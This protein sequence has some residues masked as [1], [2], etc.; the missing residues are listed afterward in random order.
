MTSQMSVTNRCGSEFVRLVKVAGA[1][2]PGSL[3]SPF[4]LNP[5][6]MPCGTAGGD[7][8]T[9]SIGAVLSRGRSAKGELRPLRASLATW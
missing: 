7:L 2:Y 6:G 4:R 3:G 8:A 1:V 5:R 9:P